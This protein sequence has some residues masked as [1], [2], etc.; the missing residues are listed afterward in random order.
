M[1][2]ASAISK[3]RP[4]DSRSMTLAIAAST[5]PT[6]SSG[7]RRESFATR[8][9]THTSASPA[10]QRR[11]TRGSRCCRSSTSASALRVAVSPVPRAIAISPR[12]KSCTEGVPSPPTW[13]STSPRIRA[14]RPYGP[15][16]G[17]DACR[18]AQCA[19]TSRS[20]TS[21]NLRDRTAPV[22]AANVAAASNALRSGFITITLEPTTD[23]QTP[24][25]PSSTRQNEVVTQS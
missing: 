8:L 16:V 6:R 4:A 14:C 11:H 22:A 15:S 21:A 3:T 5:T 18:P 1:I 23:T 25:R 13:T 24:G 20:A 10:T 17:S 7:R 12:L 19:S 9:A 2:L